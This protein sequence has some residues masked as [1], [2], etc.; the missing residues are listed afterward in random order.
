M[1]PCSRR[2]ILTAQGKELEPPLY[3]EDFVFDY[4][5]VIDSISFTSTTQATK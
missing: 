4:G 1:E 2:E 5:D 3:R